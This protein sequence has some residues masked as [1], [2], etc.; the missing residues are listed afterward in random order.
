VT[1]LAIPRPHTAQPSQARG[2]D[3]S[4][5]Y[6]RTTLTLMVIAHHSSLAYTTF[7]YFDKQ[8]MF[9]STAPIVDVT[10]W[11]FFDYAENF[12]DVF[13]MSLMFFISGLFVYQSLHKHG[14]LGFIRDRF[15]RLGVPF[16][17]AVVFLMPI[18]YYPSWQLTGQSIGFLNFYK[19]IAGI[20][21]APGPPWFIWVLLFFDVVLALALV[22]LRRWMSAA[23]SSMRSL[24]D[25]PFRTSVRVFLLAALVTLPL[26]ARYGPA[27]WT[28][29]LIGAFSFQISRIGLYALWLVFG[30]LVGIPGF[31]EGLLSRR[32]AL[33]R[34]WPRWLLGCVLA[35]NALWIYQGSRLF[36]RL[37]IMEGGFL[38][39]LLWLA[40][41]VA[42]S[43]AFL[44]LFR[45]IDLTSTRL[46]NSLSRSAYVMYL[47]HYVFVTWVQ[48]LLLNKPIH[49]GIK[50]VIVFLAATLL[51]WLTA[52]LV[53]RIPKLKMIL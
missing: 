14:T 11:V 17:F 12:N 35:Y 21:F 45:G 1:T 40:S 46:M 2:R 5:D 44:A 28:H 25:R 30:F 43:F 8:D 39:S 26:L 51:S 10:R 33:A 4:I 47:V 34:S 41:C 42:S 9:R 15:L 52:L 50:F 37:P 49:A 20:G 6:L 38:W 53:F 19:R 23:E 48:R 24:Q 31:A 16:L 27:A 22:P 13:F 29:V 18:A 7:A 36:H 3:L 32:G